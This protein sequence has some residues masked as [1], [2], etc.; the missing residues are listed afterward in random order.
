MILYSREDLLSWRPAAPT[1][2]RRTRKLLFTLRLWRP[3][4]ARGVHTCTT[5]RHAPMPDSS[6]VP[7]LGLRRLF[8]RELTLGCLNACSIRR[9]SAVLTDVL[10]TYDLDVF[11][12]TESWHKT[13]DDLSVRMMRPAGYSSLDAPRFSSAVGLRKQRGGGLVLLHKEGLS[14]KRLRFSVT[15][16]TFELLGATLTSA[17]SS[18]V[19]VVVY[20]PGGDAVDNQFFDELTAVFEQLSAYSCPLVVTGDLNLHLDVVGDVH[21]RRFH[22]TIDT[23]GLQQCGRRTTTAIRSTSLLRELIYLRLLLQSVQV[24]NTPTTRSCCSS[25]HCRVLPCSTSTSARAP[26][27]RSTLIGF[28][29]TCS[30]ASCARRRKI[31]QPCPS[32][33]C[34]TCTTA[35]CRRY[36]T[37]TLRGELYVNDISRQRRGS[38]APVLLP[39]AGLGCSS[40]ATV[41]LIVLQTAV[42]GLPKSE[43]SSDCT[44]PSR[45]AIGKLR[46]PTA[47]VNR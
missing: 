18:L 4:R 14:A 11:A 31:L 8:P 35:L 25:C 43:E 12:V 26:G 33:G 10:S 27:R 39:S 3:R 19:V 36:W 40:V 42:T 46:L 16:T 47:E 17:S 15:P 45:T 29:L 6:G 22:E 37:G 2:T 9:K 13:A 1:I 20:R 41:V 24:V 44:L 7:V 32:T 21:E 5:R 34:R 38:T 30:A 28:V 23:F